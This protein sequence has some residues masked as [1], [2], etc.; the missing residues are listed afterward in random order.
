LRHYNGWLWGQLRELYGDRVAT[1][2]K[3]LISVDKVR[4][5]LTDSTHKIWCP[6]P[7]DYKITRD[8]VEE[9]HELGGDIISYAQ[10]WS[11]PSAEGI[12]K[13]LHLS[14]KIM[15]HGETIAFFK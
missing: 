1:N 8:C 3:P 4:M 15:P 14:I 9:V 2:Y 11:S 13:A 5:G 12:E 6:T 7:E 10:Q